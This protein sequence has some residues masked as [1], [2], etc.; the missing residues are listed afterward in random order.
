MKE[1]EKIVLQACEELN[2]EFYD[3]ENERQ[4]QNKVVRI[5]A[6]T[7]EGITINQCVELNRL[8]CD[9]IP[10][11]L[12]KGEYILEVSSPGAERKLRNLDEVKASVGKHVFVKL[13]E[14]VDGMKEFEGDLEAVEGEMVTVAGKEFPYEKIATIRWA[15][16]F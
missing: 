7:E 11:D 5:L 2:V 6:D 14:K 4:G 3:I 12:I 9:L 13:Y 16:K 10:E 1:L 15:I 8:L